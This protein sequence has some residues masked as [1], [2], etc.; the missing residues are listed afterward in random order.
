MI[1]KVFH[2]IW[3]DRGSEL[4]YIENSSIESKLILYKD[5]GFRFILWVDKDVEKYINNLSRLVSMGLE[6]HYLFD[7]VKKAEINE[8]YNWGGSGDIR[9]ES[10]YYRIHL[11]NKLGG[12]YSDLDS[13][14]LRVMPDDL[15]HY[16][17]VTCYET[18]FYRKNP[19]GVCIGFFM[20]EPNSPY[21]NKFLELRSKYNYDEFSQMKLG[22]KC[23]DSEGTFILPEVA[24]L[25]ISYESR[26]MRSFLLGDK[27][28]KEV[29][30]R[31]GSY[32]FHCYNGI[33][34]QFSSS[35]GISGKRLMELKIQEYMRSITNN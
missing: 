26:M 31:Y 1:P 14:S 17:H 34:N 8:L 9:L 18:S 30:I 15:F 7:E 29:I 28:F 2:F 25:P 3:L 11:M 19:T 24:L 32:E 16:K 4:G 35:K 23:I 33:L 13:I 20:T 22:I 5:L 27:G 6:V 12:V 21:L 10:D